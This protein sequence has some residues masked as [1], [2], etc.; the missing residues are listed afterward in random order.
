MRRSDPVK[1]RDLSRRFREAGER[2]ADLAL[3]R[4]YAEEALSLA[5]EA[6][7]VERLSNKEPQEQR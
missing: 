4:I 3:K 1:L 6:E 7:A 5:Q 2:Q